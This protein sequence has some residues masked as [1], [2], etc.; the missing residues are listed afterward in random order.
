LQKTQSDALHEINRTLQEAYYA[1]ASTS[2]RNVFPRI[3]KLHRHHMAKLPVGI[4]IEREKLLQHVLAPLTEIPARLNLSEQSY[5][6][7][8]FYHQTQD[9]YS[10]KESSL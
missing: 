1:S 9:F 7:L 3:L 8:G 2:P 4:R 10:H 6:A 5:F